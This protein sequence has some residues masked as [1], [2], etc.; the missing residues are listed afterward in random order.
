MGV[1]FP[2]YIN[3]FFRLCHSAST[4]QKEREVLCNPSFKNF[5]LLKFLGQLLKKMILS[6]KIN[7]K[8]KRV[9]NFNKYL[10]KPALFNASFNNIPWGWINKDFDWYYCNKILK[11]FVLASKFHVWITSFLLILLDSFEFEKINQLNKGL[12]LF[13]HL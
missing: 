7:L 12:L 11:I 3:C 2:K 10:T 4:N 1:N 13:S 6:S 8:I 5:R 9:K